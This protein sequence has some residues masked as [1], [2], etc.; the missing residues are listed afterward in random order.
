MPRHYAVQAAQTLNVDTAAPQ[1]RHSFIIGSGIVNHHRIIRFERKPNRWNCWKRKWK[2]G[3]QKVWRWSVYVQKSSVSSIKKCVVVEGIGRWRM[4]REVV[5]WKALVCLCLG[6]WTR[7]LVLS[8]K[9]ALLAMINICKPTG[10]DASVR[11]AKNWM[12]AWDSKTKNCP[13]DSDQLLISDKWR[14]VCVR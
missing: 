14:E 1:Y 4:R 12:G 2:N 11:D 6:G 3:E 9:L 10:G 5:G 8:P 7:D 13:A